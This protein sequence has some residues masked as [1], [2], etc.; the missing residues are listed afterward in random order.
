MDTVERKI[1]TMHS[2]VDYYQTARSSLCSIA[3]VLNFHYESAHEQFAEQYD[4]E[5]EYGFGIFY[6][7]KL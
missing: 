5:N 1:L 4:S 7:L 6:I 2:R 3:M